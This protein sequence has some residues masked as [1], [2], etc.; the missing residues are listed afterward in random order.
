MVP[1]KEIFSS[2]NNPEHSNISK[3]LIFLFRTSSDIDRFDKL[4]KF[5]K[6]NK[7]GGLHS[8]ELLINEL[9]T[10]AA[11]LEVKVKLLEETLYQK[12]RNI[13]IEKVM[14]V[15]LAMKIY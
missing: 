10:I 7:K 6:E 13:H 11:I 4:R 15:A 3:I 2:C 1:L 5:L 8:A 12:L 14:T 9:K